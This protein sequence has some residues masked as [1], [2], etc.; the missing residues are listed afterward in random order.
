MTLFTRLCTTLL[1]CLLFVAACN[2]PTT[3]GAGP[4][5]VVDQFGYQPKMQKIAVLRDP[6]VGFDAKSKYLPGTTIQLINTANGQTVFEAAPTPWQNGNTDATSGDRA[7]W[8]DFSS[9]TTTGRY[10]VQ[11]PTTGSVSPEFEIKPNPYKQVLK[12]AFRTF[13]YQR[14]GFAKQQPFAEPAWE[15]SAS[16]LGP[17]QDS[18]AR[19]YSTPNDA[20]TERDLRGG[21]YDA[22]DY[23]KYTNWTADYVIGLLHAYTENPDAWGDDFNLPGSGNGVPDILDEVKWGLDFLQRMQNTN[24]SVLS[25]VG[26]DGASPPSTAKGQSLYGPASTSATLTTAGAFALAAQVFS[27]NATLKPQVPQL[28]KRATK[29][30]LW[31]DKNRVLFKNNDKASGTQGL[32]AGQQEVDNDT[33]QRK[34]LEAAAYLFELTGDPTYKDYFESHYQKAYLM[35]SGWS[36]PYL[37]QATH[38]LLYYANLKEANPKVSKNIQ[39]QFLKTMNARHVWQ[40]V[41]NEQ[42]PYRAYLSSYVWGSSGIKADKGSMFYELVL[43]N[44][45]NKSTEE[46]RNAAARYIHYLHGTNPL[47]KVYLSNMSRFGAENS[48]DQFYHTWFSHGSKKWD[49]VTASEFGPAPGFLVGG[50]NP[51]YTWDACCPNSCDG[52]N[53]RRCGIAPL[54]PPHGQPTQKSYADFNESWPLNS[55]E[56]TE[57]SNGYQVRYLRLLSKFVHQ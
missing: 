28:T 10:K 15:D 2:R 5:I 36:S 44:L 35:T 8:F 21:W 1:A 52:S 46:V 13:Y 26:L 40:A 30:W 41:T 39:A 16:H 50:A 29:A 32:G 45:G 55:W 3:Q 7:W 22:G 27:N 6:Q 54:A 24:G 11:D 17:L 14:A 37:V 18:Q 25:I 4:F 34:K 57:N 42:D 12:Q 51:K 20:S 43:F 38:L 47:G 53:N 33:R 48:V 19:L 9:V 31:A 56:V 23:N 49:S